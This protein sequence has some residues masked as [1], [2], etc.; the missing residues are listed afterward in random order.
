M[1]NQCRRV[2]S[3]YRTE[4]AKLKIITTLNAILLLLWAFHVSLVLVGLAT[5]QENTTI[6]ACHEIDA[7]TV[8]CAITT[9]TNDRWLVD[10]ATQLHEPIWRIVVDNPSAPILW[11]LPYGTDISVTRSQPARLD[12]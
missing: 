6:P 12:F 2:D 5:K 9:S 11:P 10:I 3:S 8:S 7:W 4:P 1:T